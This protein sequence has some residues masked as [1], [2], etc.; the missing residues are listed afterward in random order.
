METFLSTLLGTFLG[1]SL[2]FLIQDFR[3][4]KAFFTALDAIFAESSAYF[5]GVRA[6]R[7]YLLREASGSWSSVRS[8]QSP[9]IENN[10]LEPTDVADVL[11]SQYAQY[12]RPSDVFLLRQAQEN[13]VILVSG[14]RTASFRTENDLDEM[15]SGLIEHSARRSWILWRIVSRRD[16]A[17]FSQPAYN[18]LIEALNASPERRLAS[19]RGFVPG[20]NR[21]V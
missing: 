14:L 10:V 7:N 12:L 6:R 1:V 21:P 9:L 11:I 5:E 19:V 3:S 2:P 17:E 15:L 4:R 20:R 16:D 13:I 8:G 18:E